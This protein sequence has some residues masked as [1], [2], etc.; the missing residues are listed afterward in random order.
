MKAEVN[1]T[2]DSSIKSLL[3]LAG[4]FSSDVPVWI[5]KI[6]KA[7]SLNILV[8]GNKVMFVALK[9]GKPTFATEIASS[10]EEKEDVKYVGDGGADIGIDFN[11]FLEFM[12]GAVE[13][14]D[15]GKAAYWSVKEDMMSVVNAFWKQVPEM[16][17]LKADKTIGALFGSFVGKP[18]ASVSAE[19]NAET[20]FAKEA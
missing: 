9:D 4:G 8:D 11:A 3:S 13:R 17:V 20:N 18:L 14:K 2:P 12:L 5:E 16:I 1:I 7:D 10:K 6:G 15:E 19:V